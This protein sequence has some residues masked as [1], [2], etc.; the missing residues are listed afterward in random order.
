MLA[1]AEGY[2]PSILCSYLFTLGQVFNNFYQNVR[3]LDAGEEEREILLLLLKAV[4][5]TMRVGLDRLGI[6]TVEKM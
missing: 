5:T 6:N 4:M 3:V 1:S 2:S